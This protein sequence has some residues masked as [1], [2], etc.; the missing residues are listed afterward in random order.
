MEYDESVREKLQ[1]L[2]DF[3]EEKD[4]ERVV[5]L[6]S[7]LLDGDDLKDN[8]ELVNCVS[9][10]LRRGLAHLSRWD[11]LEKAS[12]EEESSV[13]RKYAWYQKGDYQKVIAS[14]EDK[15]ES[16]TTVEEQLL[17]AQTLHKRGQK[18]EKAYQSIL[19]SLSEDDSPDLK[20]QILINLAACQDTL[21]FVRND[22][23]QP[24]DNDNLEDPDLLF[25]EGLTLIQSARYK[26][27][28]ERLRRALNL[29]QEND[30]DE[31]YQM[32]QATLDYSRTLQER[33]VP[34]PKNDNSKKTPIGELNA[35]TSSKT[36]SEL[37]KKLPPKMTSL[38]T[39]VFLYNRCVWLVKSGDY[40]GALKSSD[41]MLQTVKRKS[42]ETQLYWKARIAVVQAT[43]YSL[44]EKSKKALELID[45]AIKSLGGENPSHVVDFC[46]S[47]LQFH[48]AEFDG[49]ALKSEDLPAS[50]IDWPAVNVAIGGSDALSKLAATDRAD[51]LLAEGK[52]EEAAGVLKGEMDIDSRSKYV[53]ALTY[54]NPE[55]ALELWKDLEIPT[56]EDAFGMTGAALEECD[57]PHNFGSAAAAIDTT[58]KEKK[59]HEAVLRQRARRAEKYVASRKERGLPTGKPDPDRWLSKYERRR[60]RR[61]ARQNNGVSSQGAA[62]RQ[63]DMDKLD[64]VALK[65]NAG[66]GSSST[67]HI[68]AVV[69]RSSR[70]R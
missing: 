51:V 1:D 49:S 14:A 5:T 58:T 20:L 30:S 11:D 13:W 3:T 23:Y 28:E 15:K 35:C 24:N 7:D 46:H 47:Y 26:E 61:G 37:Y 62:N 68:K 33:F 12:T 16:C 17:E 32:I 55:K 2:K 43:V 39:Q 42:K 31:D 64:V 18:A 67:A 25:N 52:Y 29:A 4:W 34:R 6:S 53:Y 70:R 56:S 38:Q 44:Q 45:D 59:S 19:D 10:L 65:A 63:S 36:A 21:P 66:T 22:G 41:M 50:I 40:A 57:L 60:G 27:G 69:S 54:T 9:D 8:R 48:L